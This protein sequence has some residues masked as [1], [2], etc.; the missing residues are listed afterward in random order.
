MTTN[1][2]PFNQAGHWYKGGLHIHTTESDGKITP[3]RAIAWYKN[4]GYDF[5]AITDHD[6]ITSTGAYRD[7]NFCTIPGTEI[8]TFRDGSEFHIVGLGLCQLPSMDNKDPQNIIDEMRKSGGLCFLAHPFWSDLSFQEVLSLKGIFGMEIFN[9]V[10]W[11]EIQ[12]GHSLAHW[13]WVLHRGSHLWGLA[14]D[15]SH[16]EYPGSGQAWVMVKSERL[17]QDSILEALEKG[18]FYSSTGPEIHDIKFENGRVNVRCSP[19]RSVF[20]VGNGSS[21]RGSMHFA[22][23]FPYDLK[24]EQPWDTRLVKEPITELNMPISKNQEY[25]RVEV[26]DFE[27][28]SAWSNPY[29]L[30][31]DIPHV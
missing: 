6:H 1:I 19:A 9:S 27:G 21:S 20:I 22:Q 15:D 16:W 28:R 14:T 18:S 4:Q 7:A 3:E 10:C 17:D 13:D 2:S 29:F 30:T 23:G 24:V 26:V 12:K 5:L 11:V 31:A 25:V 8:S